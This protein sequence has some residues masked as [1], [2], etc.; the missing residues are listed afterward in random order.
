MAD[1][2]LDIDY[3]KFKNPNNLGYCPN[4]EC[5]IFG[6]PEEHKPCCSN[7]V[8]WSIED[9]RKAL[10]KDKPKKSFFQ[11]LMGR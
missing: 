9:V 2:I 7:S 10:I 4:C 8:P 1:G 11:R 6:T 5:Y 3:G